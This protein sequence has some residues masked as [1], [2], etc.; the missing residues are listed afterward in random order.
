MDYI[1]QLANPKIQY[2]YNIASSNAQTCNPIYNIRNIRGP[3]EAK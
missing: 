1:L 3:K 2:L